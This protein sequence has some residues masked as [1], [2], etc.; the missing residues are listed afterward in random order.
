MVPGIHCFIAYLLE[1]RQVR[2]ARLKFISSSTH[3]HV[4]GIGG[5][6]HAWFVD[7][8]SA[9]FP[10]LVISASLSLVAYFVVYA[11]VRNRL[12]DLTKPKL[13]QLFGR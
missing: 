1:P 13:E 8:N 6:D 11:V 10:I 3:A 12:R 7:V 4:D 9:D 5:H 2:L